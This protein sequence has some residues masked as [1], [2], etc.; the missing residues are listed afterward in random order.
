MPVPERVRL[1]DRQASAAGQPPS[2]LH[3][4]IHPAP[5][6]HS[7]SVMVNSLT[8][9]GAGPCRAS[10]RALCHQTTF[11]CRDDGRAFMNVRLKVIQS[12]E[13]NHVETA[14]T[15][16]FEIAAVAHVL[17]SEQGVFDRHPKQIGLP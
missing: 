6:F 3:G 9:L 5:K 10:D 7:P 8:N 17:Q 13:V 16:V 15:A 12:P 4:R 2:S 1:L 11:I 14:L